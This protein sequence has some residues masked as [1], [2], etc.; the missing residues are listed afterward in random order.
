M[1]ISVILPTYNRSHLIER[2]LNS[3]LAQTDPA[4]EVIIVDDGSTDQ[5]TEIL[6]QYKDDVIILSQPNR[7]VSAARNLGINEASGDWIAFL[8]SD[9]QWH[10]NK[11]AQQ[12]SALESHAG[13]L[14]CHTDEIWIRNGVRVNPMKKHNKP[15][16]WIFTQCLPLC[17]VSPSTILVAKEVFSDVGVFDP[18]LPACEDYDLWLRIFSRYPILLVEE[19]LITKYGGHD[20]QLSVRYWGMDRFRVKALI[21]LLE[22]GTLN[23]SQRQ[24]TKKMLLKKLTIL[25][26]GSGKRAKFADQAHYQGLID[27]WSGLE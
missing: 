9:D 11:L 18:Q 19:P 23:Q 24:D 20:D 5:T 15:N 27:D 4:W 8:D 7:G 17:C 14:V 6:D 25:R 21:K 10:P 22:G 3:I 13:F 16:G 26:N 12:K 1:K 2:S